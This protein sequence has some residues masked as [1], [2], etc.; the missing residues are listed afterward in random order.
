M[1]KIRSSLLLS[2]LEKY[3]TLAIQIVATIVTARL[4]TPAETGLYSVASALVGVAQ[5]LRDFGICSYVVQESELSAERHATA[6]GI[7][8]ALG[9]LMASV[10]A[11]TSGWV[12]AF[13]AEPQLQTIV[14]IL[15]A[16]FIL[17]AFSSIGQAQ[18]CRAM[19]F[20]A[21]LRIGIVATSVHAITMVVLADLGYGALSMA[22]ASVLSIAAQFIGYTI[23]Y[24]KTVLTIPSFKEWRRV[25]NF[26]FFVS[27]GSLLQELSQ[28]LPD[29]VVGRMLGFSAAGFYSRGNGL[30]NLFELAFMNGVAPVASSAMA[31]L[32]R[33]DQ[34][35][36]NPYL[37][38]L[39]LTTVVAW[40]F[41]G[42]LAL[43]AQP[44]V[45]LAF[46]DQW[47][48][49]VPI[50]QILCFGTAIGL[51]GRLGMSMFTATG[52]VRRLLA[53]Q[54]IAVPA[55]ALALLI[56]ARYS[57]EMAAVGVGVGG[58]ALAS[59]SLYHS[60]RALGTTWL[61]IVSELTRSLMI[62]VAS[63]ALPSAIVLT[64]GIDLHNFWPP[65]LFAGIAG[66]ASW[67]VCLFIVG[68][69]IKSEILL[70]ISKL[71]SARADLTRQR[72]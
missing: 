16:N 24:P 25:C 15:C 9:C 57:T 55:Q 17:V 13:F 71:R 56:G 37:K 69:P 43:L 67:S 46:G 27:G 61:Q 62:T 60:N 39:G 8:L 59:L 38:M 30:V 54:L 68:H 4:L 44:M 20:G 1:E 21:A 41:L 40:P 72:G 42:M 2:F 3:I 33:N 14:L 31:H 70:V 49:A 7:A 35:M 45:H 63:L 65:T 26:G 34:S 12:A 19:N 29:I 6:L 22:W 32:N 64:N 52:H 11:M 23:Y 47:L 28:R 10:F 51:L 50:A 18:L 53:V 36:V 66:V 58:L 5:T 48:P